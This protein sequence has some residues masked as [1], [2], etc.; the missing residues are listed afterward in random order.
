MTGKLIIARVKNLITAR[1][2][3]IHGIIYSLFLAFFIWLVLLAWQ[4]RDELIF[5][6]GKIDF[7]TFVLSFLFYSVALFLAV[8]SWTA[9]I[10]VFT[11]GLHWGD[12]ARIYLLTFAARR[13]PGTIWYIGG[14][15]VLYKKL[16][17]PQVKTLTASSIELV[18][19]IVADCV[20]GAILL[21]FGLNID[22]IFLIPLIFVALSG[23]L[24]IHPTSLKWL[25]QKLNRQLDDHIRIRD[26][27]T[28]LGIKM[29]LVIA[30]GLMIVQIISAFQPLATYAV[31]IVLGARA[32]SGAASILTYFLPS[33]M[34]ASDLTLIALL[35]TILPVSV[36]GLIGIIVRLYTTFL[37][38]LIGFVFY[39][40]FRN[41]MSLTQ[42]NR[43]S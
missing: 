13:L 16:G 28:W 36:A 21:P 43:N 31:I 23:L 42:T 10:R 11:P 30:G 35:S 26:L 41:S 24:L 6:L 40:L 38:I 32:I 17:V 20:L 9:I 14:R 34:G 1:K 5:F 2:A 33:S 8:F 15:M 27:I 18:L 12:H 25:L 39:I 29:M 19:G 37:E 7:P 3:W 4:S 22:P